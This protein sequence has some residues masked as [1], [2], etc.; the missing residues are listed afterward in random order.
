MTR[1][2]ISR[3]RF[4]GVAAKA[5]PGPEGPDAIALPADAMITAV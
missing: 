3:T 1:L 5:P 2:E 4:E